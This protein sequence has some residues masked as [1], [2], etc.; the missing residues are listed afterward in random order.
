MPAPSDFKII[1]IDGGAA[2]GKSSTSRGLADKLDLMHVDTGAHYRTLTY[3]MLKVGASPESDNISELLGA[4]SLDTTL[5]GRSARLS[6]NNE[7]PADSAI[8]SPEVN[9]N[10]SKFAAIE[11]VRQKLFNYQRSL[12]EVAQSAN[13]TG[14][15]MEGRDIGSI[16]FPDAD[17]RFFLHADEATRAARRAN[18]GQ[19][20][21]IAARD[22]MDK[23]RKTAPLVCPEGATQVDTAPFTL[24]EVIEKIAKLILNP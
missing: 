14:L 24:E 12:A 1:A 6:I 11:T 23:T 22:Q 21:S 4:L 7:V 8:R 15:V 9:A 16:I 18:E 13:Y 2:T 19:T 5:E 20:D 3:A 10:V 17:H